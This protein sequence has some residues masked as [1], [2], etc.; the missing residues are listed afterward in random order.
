MA[1]G[2]YGTYKLLLA[3]GPEIENVSWH[4]ET[5]GT[6]CV[7]PLVVPG[8]TAYKVSGLFGE[9]MQTHFAS[10]KYRFAVAEFGTYDPIRVLG[11]I[12]A[13]NRVHHY[14]VENSAIYK[15]TKAELLECFCP[16]DDS[17]REQIIESSL[18]IVDQA[19]H[20]LDSIQ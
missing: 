16:D 19:T 11:A 20:G 1:L 17:W 14:G 7:E 10:R 5:F 6:D 8:G 13:E 15:S 4:N 2:P 12:R 9:W 18:R 3:K